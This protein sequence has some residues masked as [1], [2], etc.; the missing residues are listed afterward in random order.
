LSLDFFFRLFSFLIYKIN[1]RPRFLLFQE[2]ETFRGLAQ[3]V[4]NRSVE[5]MKVASTKVAKLRAAGK[6]SKC[7]VYVDACRRAY[8]AVRK[9]I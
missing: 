6:E 3:D 4:V 2:Q 5:V 1:V 9:I 7:Q 8:V